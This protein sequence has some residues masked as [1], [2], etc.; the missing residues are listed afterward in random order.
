MR[1]RVK[2]RAKKK[3]EKKND[4]PISPD[5]R[6]KPDKQITRQT[7]TTACKKGGENQ[8]KRRRRIERGQ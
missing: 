4:T 8:L 5:P 2:K 3:A 7:M 1:K 6:K